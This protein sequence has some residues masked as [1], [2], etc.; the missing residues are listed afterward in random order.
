MRRVGLDGA[1]GRHPGEL[2]GGQR[3]RVAIARA[4][5][6]EPQALLIDEPLASVDVDLRRDLLSLFVRA[7]ALDFETR[8]PI[9]G[10]TDGTADGRT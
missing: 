8:G 3:Q 10:I 9:V 2:S 5:V 6:L 7:L 4:L 1:E